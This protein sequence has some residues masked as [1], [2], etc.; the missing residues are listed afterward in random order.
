MRHTGHVHLLSFSD[1]EENNF[2]VTLEQT[3]VLFYTIWHHIIFN[4]FPNFGL[5]PECNWILRFYFAYP[6]ALRTLSVVYL[7]LFLVSLFCYEVEFLSCYVVVNL[8]FGWVGVLHSLSYLYVA[9]LLLKMSL[10][11]LLE[12]SHLTNCCDIIVI[13]W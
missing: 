2:A 9:F 11:K 7:L 4:K 5:I 10:K 6:R 12:M 1:W 8:V 3:V 13:P